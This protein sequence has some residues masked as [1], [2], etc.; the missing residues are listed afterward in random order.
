MILTFNNRKVNKQTEDQRRTHVSTRRLY[1]A[2][3]LN[4]LGALLK[5]DIGVSLV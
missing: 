5:A 4:I 1:P 3:I 2:N